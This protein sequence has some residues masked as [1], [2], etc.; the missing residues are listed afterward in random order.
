MVLE[1]AQRQVRGL[2]SK[3]NCRTPW[4]LL[5]GLW[6]SLQKSSDL[7]D[8]HPEVKQ[9][10]PCASPDA[11]AIN[12][13]GISGL[14]AGDY[15]HA[16][17][18]KLFVVNPDP[19]SEPTDSIRAL[20]PFLSSAMRSTSYTHSHTSARSIRA[21]SRLPSVDPRTSSSASRESTLS[22]ELA[23]EEVEL[24]YHIIFNGLRAQ[25]SRRRVPQAL[26]SLNDRCG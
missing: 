2:I 14:V 18:Q 3:S 20:R 10:L 1:Q 6:K 17:P 19:E 11:Q 12:Y 22:F 9:T 16:P 15:M 4:R 26:G 25:V 24:F 23:S 21:E 8:T 13:N 5:Q 7:P